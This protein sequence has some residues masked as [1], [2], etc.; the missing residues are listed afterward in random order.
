M[1]SRAD[2]QDLCRV[3]PGTLMGDLIRQYWIPAMLSSELP[4]PDCPP[5]RL[6][7]LGEDVVAFRDTDG[8]L[9]LVAENCPHRGASLFFGRN[10]ESGLRCVYH[11]WKFDATGACVDMPNEPPESNFKHKVRVTAYSCTERNGLI[12]AYM[13]ARPTPPPLPDIE[14]NML[15]E[16]T[17]SV[18]AG[19]RE[20]NFVQAFEG[21]IDTCHL[22]FLHQGSYDPAEATPGSFSYYGL[23]ERAPKYAVV[24]TDY[25]TMYGAYRPAAEDTYYWR[26]AQFLLPFWTMPPT[27]V[28][29]VK[30]VARAWVP[31]DD[32]HTMFF[33]LTPKLG[34]VGSTSASPQ[35]SSSQLLTPAKLLPN[36]SGPHGRFRLEANKRNDYLID[37]GLQRA[38]KNYTGI[39]GIH[40]QD[41]AVTESMGPIYDRTKERLGTS[42]SMIIRTRRR[43]LQVARDLRE[44]GITPPGVED[45]SI[46]GVRAGGV[47][48]K[49]DA[50]WL[51][52]TERLR[53]AFVKH[54]KLSTE[55]VG[56]I[57][58]S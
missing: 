7:L 35:V 29:G 36:T 25:G 5:V 53:Q 17:Y 30:I 58:G 8:M 49:R 11:G 40:L 57:P 52:A 31:I 56:N 21:D 15:P 32:E 13:G 48:L 10:E 47:I 38:G 33:M 23:A 3:G 22:G 51:A 44:R 24:E 26:I 50:D 46:F 54:T 43:L 42:D 4:G 45:P 1:L 20:C 41:Q 18:W 55:I 39:T 2:N 6:R 12:W 28:L 34:T 19:M 9:T 27:N 16:G 14:A 37:R